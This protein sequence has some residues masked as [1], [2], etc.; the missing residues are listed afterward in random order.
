MLRYEIEFAG[1]LRV[2]TLFQKPLHR[3]A[4]GGDAQRRDRCGAGA[5][6]PAV[7]PGGRW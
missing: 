2:D 5:E 6:L 1:V 4:A 3:T 7:L